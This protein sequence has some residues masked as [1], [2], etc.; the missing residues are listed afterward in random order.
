MGKYATADDLK[1]RIGVHVPLLGMARKP[2]PKWEDVP[3]DAR[4]LVRKVMEIAP[5]NPHLVLWAHHADP[6][7]VWRAFV[8]VH[9]P[10]MAWDVPRAD[11]ALAQA[12]ELRLAVRPNVEGGPKFWEGVGLIWGDWVYLTA[13]GDKLARD[14]SN[15]AKLAP[16]VQLDVEKQ[17]LVFG[18]LKIRLTAERLKVLK[19]LW[20]A[21]PEAVDLKARFSRPGKD[22]ASELRKSLRDA[23][24]PELAAAIKSQSGVGHYLDWPQ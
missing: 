7:K 18:S 10:G 16:T 11:R 24:A 8:N 23:N 2:H 17:T 12:V 4:T 21:R 13:L 14:N 22:V 20:D 15:S 3:P 19:A 5:E 9:L 6:K 1:R